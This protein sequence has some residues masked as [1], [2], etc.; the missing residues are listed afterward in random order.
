MNWDL[1]S[2]FYIVFANILFQTSHRFSSYYMYINYSTEIYREEL[3][4]FYTAGIEMIGIFFYIKYANNALNAWILCWILKICIKR[5]TRIYIDAVSYFFRIALTMWKWIS[6]ILSTNTNIESILMRLKKCQKLSKTIVQLYQ[7][8]LSSK[9][10]KHSVLLLKG[11]QFEV[12]DYIRWLNNKQ[13][14]KSNNKGLQ[15]F[16]KAQQ[17]KVCNQK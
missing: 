9:L 1:Q 3:K 12:H 17:I 4:Y 13:K 14:S 16:I 2:T 15:K 10:K 6:S 8:F 7:I 5:M 11:M